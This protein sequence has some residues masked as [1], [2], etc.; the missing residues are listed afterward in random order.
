[1]LQDL[2]DTVHLTLGVLLHYLGKMLEFSAN[3]EENANRLHLLIASNF[4]FIHKF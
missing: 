1:M 2:Y 4:V 3:V